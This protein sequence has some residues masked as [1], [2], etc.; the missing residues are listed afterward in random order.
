MS[1]QGLPD[2]QQP[3]QGEG[4]AV[5]YPF[6]GVGSHFVFPTELEIAPRP[7]GRP[8]FQLELVRGANPL[9]PPAPYGV[10]EL[11][12]L[13][14]Y[15]A[16][17]ALELVRARHPRAQLGFP[18]LEDGYLRLHSPDE[19]AEVPAE[20]TDPSALGWG[21]LSR[22][23]FVR[24]LSRDGAAVLRQALEGDA[25]PLIAWADVRIDGVSP[26]LPV[27]VRLAPAP[28]LER[29]A[30]GPVTLEAI[31][32]AVFEDASRLSIEVVGELADAE[33]RDF[34]AAVAD[35]FAR[36]HAAFRPSPPD[37]PGACLA[38]E[39]AAAAASDRVEWDLAQPLRAPRYFVF[40]LDPL[41]AAR[42]LI[43]GE[44]LAS[45]VRQTV[46][47]P[48]PTGSHLVRVSANLPAHRPGVLSAGVTLRVPPAPP[49]RPHAVV[50]SVE[51]EPPEDA[52]TVRLRL[53]PGEELAY[54]Y[55][56]LV[57]VQLGSGFE[58]LTAPERPHQGGELSLGLSDFPVA[59]FAVGAAPALLASADL[60]GVCRVRAGGET[61][62]QGF[63]LSPEAPAVALPLPAGAHAESVAVE[64]TARQGEGRLTL[65]LPARPGMVL[66]LASFPEYGLHHVEIDCRFEAGAPELAAVELAAEDPAVGAETTVLHFTPSRPGRRFSYLARSPFRAGYRYRPFRGPGET[67]AEWSPVRS[68]FAG[69]RLAV[70]PAGLVAAAPE[71]AQ[72][73]A[74][75]GV[76][77]GG[78]D[79]GDTP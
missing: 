26:R 24:R 7:D 70:T 5:Y 23:R 13:P 49:H 41:A 72:F 46:V 21:G 52:A 45:V 55:A 50:E 74:A 68:P 32:E 15:P 42:A 12:L 10:L 29:L 36:R 78:S 11:R 16:A 77:P 40:R 6:E 9:L 38:L 54:S 60:S 53:A 33:R 31:A 20:L 43:A 58:R 57:V 25:L 8:D 47:P 1:L 34:A 75:A 51:L 67:A 3:L 73:P 2:F 65:E 28:L 59:F 37:R 66:D 4:F 79:L 56:P 62:E 69:L 44:G 48:L 39:P 64:A 27:R 18:V 35:R 17:E 30:D 63:T 14:L 71:T 76:R 19:S 22:A 61:L